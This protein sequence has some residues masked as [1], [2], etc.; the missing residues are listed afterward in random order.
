MTEQ[1]LLVGLAT[2]EKQ[3][4]VLT[5]LA[6]LG[7]D[8]KLELIRALLAGTLAV[9]GPLTNAQLTALSL[10]TNAKGEEVRA[11]L[12]GTLT[13]RPSTDQDP[14]FDETNGEKVS[15]TANT[16][17]DIITPPA[18]CK[19]VRISASADTFIATNNPGTMT[20]N[21]ENILVTAGQPEI[22]PVTAGVTVRGLSTTASV[23]RAMPLKVR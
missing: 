2:E 19:F 15:L 10:M 21:G 5:A 12:A 22:V 7:T 3:D 4:A 8:A 1:S 17:A 13:A 11:L 9:S 14:I 16:A 20:D 23:V 18:G 6:L